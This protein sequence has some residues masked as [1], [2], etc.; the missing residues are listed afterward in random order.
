L[1][2]LEAPLIY[3]KD[4]YF[5]EEF[6]P[7]YDAKFK[8]V[9][10]PVPTPLICS[11]TSLSPSEIEAVCHIHVLSYL[12]PQDILSL[13]R[14]CKTAWES[15]CDI[16]NNVS[17][18]SLMAPIVFS[19]LRLSREVAEHV[20]SS[21]LSWKHHM[22]PLLVHLCEYLANHVY[23]K[24]SAST[25]SGY[26][27][28][29]LVHRVVI[30]EQACYHAVAY[31][32]GRVPLA[33]RAYSQLAYYDRLHM[34]DPT[35]NGAAI[36]AA[37]AFIDGAGTNRGIGHSSSGSTSIRSQLR[38]RVPTLQHLH[39]MVQSCDLA[40]GDVSILHWNDNARLQEWVEENQAWMKQ[41]CSTT[42]NGKVVCPW[43]RKEEDM[44]EQSKRFPHPLY[45]ARIMADLHPVIWIAY[46]SD[47][48]LE[49]QAWMMSIGL[50]GEQGIVSHNLRNMSTGHDA[51][52]CI[53]S[54]YF[55]KPNFNESFHCLIDFVVGFVFAK[56]PNTSLS[57]PSL[58]G[59][60]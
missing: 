4:D 3:V 10:S 27:E 25:K 54:F 13:W 12:A 59:A 44:E 15:R 28:I 20:A 14:T 2:R 60:I 29:D 51:C 11:P 30:A 9:P 18:W 55:L 32:T 49:R 7:E 39:D 53:E 45:Y 17:S 43:S 46:V 47:D 22:G 23:G 52:R 40:C 6:E 36:T 34:R 48:Q 1:V 35:D 50:N 31:S 8:I 38:V 37:I 26:I 41:T 5:V 19:Y 33:P 58:G 56:F 21:P 16:P 57:N 24:W 42:T